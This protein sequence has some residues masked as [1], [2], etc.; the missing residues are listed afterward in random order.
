M[1]DD[2]TGDR[3]TTDERRA[4]L[5]HNDTR[6]NVASLLQ[7]PVGSTRELHFQLDRLPLDTDLVALD[8]R[9]DLVLTRIKG[10]ILV[11]ADLEAV[12]PL[13]C[14]TCLAEYEQSVAESFSEPFRQTVDV[15]TGAS[16]A[17]D[18]RPDEQ[19]ED[20]PAFTIDEGH[21]L[22]LREAFRQWFV[23]AIPMQPSCGPNCP[24]PE[25]IGD[26]SDEVIDDRFASLASLLD[27]ANDQN[28]PAT[29]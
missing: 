15:R 6:I 16:M 22:D 14:A 5:V 7:E 13:E 19:D 1:A 11:D 12:I 25:A 29:P 9:G 27:D 4:G 28:E 24:G 8:V 10:A 20:E 18:E 26:G 21:E 17:K 3:M 2:R 23:L